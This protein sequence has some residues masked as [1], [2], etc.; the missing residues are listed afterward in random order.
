M[1]KFQFFY[2]LEFQFLGFR[3]HGWQ[4]QP[5]LKTLHDSIDKTLSFV[6]GDQNFKTLGASRTDAK[7][8]SRSSRVELFVNEPFASGEIFLDQINQ[9]LPF[10][11]RA[12]NIIETNKSFNIIQDSGE[13]EY[14][15]YFSHGIKADPYS[16]PFVY[17][18]RRVLD[19]KKMEE[20]AM[21][22]QG[23]H[24]FRGFCVQPKED[25]STVR[26]VSKS[27]ITPN[28]GMQASFFPE[29][30]FIYKVRSKGFLRNQVRLMMG[31][32]LELGEGSC[33]NDELKKRMR[34]GERTHSISSLA[35]ASGLHLYKTEITTR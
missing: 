27:I 30:T 15:Y 34:S 32:L 22:F 24:D 9:N 16:A 25:Q 4:K 2:I 28:D 11:I 8:S 10:D 26:L 19:I 7:V 31:A 20:G 23:E 14:H 3:F 29:N 17:S 12:I 35:P 33:T 13:K 18:H 6:L 1:G 21:L 5:K